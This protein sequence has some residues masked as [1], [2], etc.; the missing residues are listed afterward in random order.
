MNLTPWTIA[1]AVLLFVGTTV[2]TLLVGLFVVVRL[3]E[4]YFVTPRRPRP[5]HALAHIVL[6]ALKNLA[7]LALVIVGVA[8]SLPGIPGQG[9]LTVFVGAMLIDFP[10]KFRLEQRVIGRPRIL[11]ALNRIRARR[12]RPPLL[13]PPDGPVDPSG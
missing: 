7:G 13:P 1:G 9:L 2:F 10:G 4:D 5:R 6:V 3:P 12:G 8:L 11:A